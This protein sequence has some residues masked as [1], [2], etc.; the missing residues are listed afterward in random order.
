M[1]EMV[2]KTGKLVQFEFSTDNLTIYEMIQ[3]LVSAG[4]DVDEGDSIE[5]DSITGAGVVV[6]NGVV[7]VV[8]NLVTSN[9]DD[10]YTN[11]SP[12]E[13]GSFNFDTVF[14][15]GSSFLEERLEEAFD[16]NINSKCSR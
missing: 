6:V 3:E 10:G 8:E 7:Y 11:V 1:S 13:D 15:T 16:D 14:Y 12:N 4:V 2:R 9:P 5:Y